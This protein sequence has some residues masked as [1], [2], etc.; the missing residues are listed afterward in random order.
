LAW[1]LAEL[2]ES[3]LQQSLAFKGGTALKRCYFGD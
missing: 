3:D 2:A 1:F